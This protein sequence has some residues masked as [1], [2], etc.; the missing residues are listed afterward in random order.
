MV[1][2][3]E[4]GI[5]LDTGPLIALL[6]GNDRHHKWVRE[7]WSQLSFPLLVCEPVLAQAHYLARRL[8]PGAQRAIMQFFE[9]GM[10]RLSFSLAEELVAVGR[11]L[12]KYEDVPMSL[13]NGCIVRMA[14]QQSRS[15]VFTLD[16]DFAVYRKHGSQRIPLLS[17]V[18]S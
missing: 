1:S 8:G 18:I 16:S 14:E 10:F 6:N 7:T 12:T 5:I 13:A 2:V 15:V 11:L 9:R 3:S 17:S 4:T